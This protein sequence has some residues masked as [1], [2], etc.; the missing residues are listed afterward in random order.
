MKMNKQTIWL[1]TM[2]SLMVVL[3]AYYMITGPVEPAVQTSQHTQNEQKEKAKVDVNVKTVSKE[4]EEGSTL[5]KHDFF[6]NY[7]LQRD[8][9]RAKLTE[10]YM[11]I[12]SNPDAAKKELQE[13]E[14]KINQLM[15]IDKQEST[16]EDM[17]RREGF[18]DAVVINQNNHV[19]VVVQAEKLTEEQVIAIISMMGKHFRVE[20]AQISVQYQV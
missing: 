16:A 5:G 9:L 14:A 19:D 10:E 3:S 17:I 15:K 12:L 11:R 4:I 20:P 7:H 2:L 6:I 13:A 8:T 1:V 18:R